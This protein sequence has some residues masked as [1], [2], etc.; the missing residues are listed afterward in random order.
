MTQETVM[1]VGFNNYTRAGR[2]SLFVAHV[3][4][5]LS[6]GEK[7]NT[8]RPTPFSSC[9]FL[10]FFFGFVP[11]LLFSTEFGMGRTWPGRIGCSTAHAEHRIELESSDS[12]VRKKKMCEITERMVGRRRGGGAV[13]LSQTRKTRAENT[14]RTQKEAKQGRCRKHRQAGRKSKAKQSKNAEA[15]N[16]ET[17]KSKSKK[18]SVSGG[19]SSYLIVAASDEEVGGSCKDVGAGGGETSTVGR[20]SWVGG[21]GGRG[22]RPRRYEADKDERSG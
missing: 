15:E 20:G 18:G 11:F 1:V 4:F 13:S 7:K 19:G 9:F 5:V 8:E 3:I 21:A 22:V 12:A 10:L 17:R 6:R 2:V 14:S 16:A